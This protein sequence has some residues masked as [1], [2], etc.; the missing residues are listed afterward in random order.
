MPLTDRPR[1]QMTKGPGFER[2]LKKEF[3]LSKRVQII[4][5]L[6]VDIL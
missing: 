4:A 2:G 5:S 3:E 1:P 6:P